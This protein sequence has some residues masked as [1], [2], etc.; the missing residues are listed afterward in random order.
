MDQQ[1]K[2]SGTSKH[3]FNRRGFLGAA[4]A[5]AAFASSTTWTSRSY[6]KIV[7]ANERIRHALIGPGMGIGLAHITALAALQDKD[8]L[9]PVA[10][11]DCW[12]RRA[13]AAANILANGPQGNPSKYE[14]KP[15]TDYR[16]ILDTKDLNY[17]TIGTP[18]HWHS[19]M[20]MEAMD[21]GLAVYCEKPMTHSIPE[22]IAVWKK[23]QATGRPLQVGVQGM[24]DDSYESA[25]KAIEDGVL[26]QVVQAQIE[27]V[28]R[29]GAQGPWRNPDL[30][31]KNE[32][33]PA[34]L[35]WS[36]WLGHAPKIDWNPHHYFEW[37]N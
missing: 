32:T 23:Q 21:A 37:R 28:R 35:N 26:G 1:D 10:V 15:Y 17:V 3:G 5:A 14:V 20:T 11:A 18:E 2:T 33:K 34:D 8:N 16:K 31:E 36:N 29:Y 12:K 25:A 13:A 22:G 30:V 6:G 7:G 24:S 27:Y 19:R 9:E 4:G